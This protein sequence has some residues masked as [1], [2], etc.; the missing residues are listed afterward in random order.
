MKKNILLP[1]FMLCML[2]PVLR[3][4]ILS[5][6]GTLA[7]G[8]PPAM[9]GVELG[10]GMHTQLGEFEAS[11]RC[12]FDGGTGTGFL[13]GLLFELPL[14]Y[15]WTIGLGA[16]FDFKNSSS[17]THVLDTATITFSNT[18]D[19]SSG[20]FAFE[21]DGD[22]KETFL[23]LA[24]FVRYELARNGPFVQIG[25]GIGFVLSSHFTHTR[26]LNSS[27][28]EVTSPSGER[29]TLTNVR[30]QNGTR[31][32]T[33]QDSAI[34]NVSGTRISALATFG[35]N[36]ALGD[37]A[38]IAPM[39]TYDFPFTKVRDDLDAN[40]PNGSQNWKLA[41]LYFSVGLKYKLG[42]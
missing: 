15:E 32:E 21:R 5:G 3:A 10:L 38:V 26:V 37:H 11:C 9:I 18:S 36:L 2:T 8:A 40:Q 33:L 12:E 7:P 17:V 20:T 4:Q 23:T 22:V 35:W 14:D 39:I 31:E 28:I 27:T 13:G 30:F 42:D 19:V 24:P 16:K 6:G 34:E 41:T 1:L 25:P 29:T